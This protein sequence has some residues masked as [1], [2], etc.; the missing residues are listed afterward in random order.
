MPKINLK[1]SDHASDR[2]FQTCFA[3]SVPYLP[4]SSQHQQSVN[5]NLNDCRVE[6][7]D[8]D[9]HP[10]IEERDELS[11]PTSESKS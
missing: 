4:Q 3:G 8:Q 1:R 6:E 10:L 11:I 7:I 2:L 5:H 9:V